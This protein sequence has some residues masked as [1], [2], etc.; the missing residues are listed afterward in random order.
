MA[1]GGQLG[2]NAVRFLD[3]SGCVRRISQLRLNGEGKKRARS[4]MGWAFAF[5]REQSR[6]SR[7]LKAERQ[8]CETLLPD[9]GYR[10]KV[11]KGRRAAGGAYR[12][13]GNHRGR[14][15]GLQ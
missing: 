3:R 12:T 7:H 9:S 6:R 2:R 15:A 10:I 13:H 11:G 4:V 5:L 1:R 14:I 8:A